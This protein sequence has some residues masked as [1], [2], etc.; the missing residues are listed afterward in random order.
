M[1]AG[2]RPVA[3]RLKAMM[4]ARRIGAL[5]L[6]LAIGAAALS[7]HAEDEKARELVEKVEETRRGVVEAEAQKRKVLGSLYVIN[8]R[9]KKISVEKGHLTDELFQ[10]QDNVK[11]IAKVI[12]GLEEQIERQRHLLRRR[13]R[14]LYKL[15]GEGYLAILF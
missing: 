5:A 3:W 9:M 1:T 10:V 2:R 7:A 8:Q 15:S 14:A 12:A 6:A 11:Q 13:L 4:S